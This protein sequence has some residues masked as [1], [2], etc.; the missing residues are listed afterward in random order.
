M[1]DGQVS[2]ILSKV[3]SIEE[4]EPG[5]DY[6][7]GLRTEGMKEGLYRVSLAYGAIDSEE[8][9]KKAEKIFEIKSGGLEIQK[10]L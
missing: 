5:N 10:R 8:G 9:L 2:E 1:P 7:F 3:Y 6:S 4:L